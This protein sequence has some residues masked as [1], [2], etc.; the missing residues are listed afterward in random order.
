MMLDVSPDERET[1][2]RSL[3]DAPLDVS[4]HQRMHVLL[5]NAGDVAGEA[6]HELALA[7]FDLF[8]DAPTAQLSLV[9]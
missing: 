2:D 6:A 7:A 9:L 1:L 5:R 4:L 8:G 3:D